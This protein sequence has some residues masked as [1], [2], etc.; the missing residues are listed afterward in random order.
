MSES[1]TAY[2]KIGE[3][4]FREVSGLYYE[5]FEVGNTYEHRPGRTITDV[6]NI[7]TTLLTMN[8]QQVHF[9][10]A[11]ASHTEWKKLLVDS[12]FTLALLTGMSVRTVSAKVVA[13]LGWNN[14]RATHPVFAGD[15]LY[16][17]STVLD[18]RESKSRPTQG[19][20]TVLT[21]GINQDGKLVMSF[22]R[23]M[24]VYRRGH[25]PE[26]EANY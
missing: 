20:V 25:S 2:R 16:A 23:T 6:D 26:A 12:T 14:V 5:D 10:Q 15:T 21:H 4:R 19:I 3:N 9:D 7:W 13:N 8:T 1:I 11:Y 24:L 17:E 18:K 22:E